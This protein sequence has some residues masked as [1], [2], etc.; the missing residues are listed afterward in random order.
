MFF[1]THFTR[2]YAF[3][4]LFVGLTPLQAVHAHDGTV[5]IT[6]NIVASSC[7][8]ENT[9]PIDVIM[10]DVQLSTF[11]AVGDVSDA[12]S[13]NILLNC[14]TGITGGTIT[15]QGTPDQ[16]N[17]DLLQVTPGSGAATGV[18]VEITDPSNGNAS[19]A[20]GKATQITA[21][22]TDGG[23]TTLPYNLRYKSTQATVTAGTANAV[24]YF[25]L[26]Y[27]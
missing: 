12:K 25:D 11:K 9:D 23:E 7:N 20:L 19:V 15:F 10:D 17:S 2:R 27:Q 16:D 13:F 3:A 8:V 26:S 5:N 18:A 24:M 1:L 22:L 6:G 14:D 21:S 4:A